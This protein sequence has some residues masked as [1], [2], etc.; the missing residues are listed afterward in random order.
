MKGIDNFMRRKIK[1]K[2]EYCEQTF[3]NVEDCR[4]HEQM[5]TAGVVLYDEKGNKIDSNAHPIDIYYFSVG[6]TR[7]SFD[8]LDD[9]LGS[10]PPS[11]DVKFIKNGRYYWD[12]E[13]GC[14]MSLE[15]LINK[16]EE[17]KKVFER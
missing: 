16:V 8:F 10:V 4:Q 17:I 15:E 12:A 6:K 7:E 13:Q 11:D 14:W 9:Y 1:Y 5:H 3:E 2:C